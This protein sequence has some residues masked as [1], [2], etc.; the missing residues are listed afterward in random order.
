MYS[1]P[2]QVSGSPTTTTSAPAA[3]PTP[4]PTPQPQALPFNAKLTSDNIPKPGGGVRSGACS[5]SLVAPQWVV[6]AGHCFHDVKDRPVSGKPLYTMKVV[7]GKLK[8]SDAGGYTGEVID[9]R[10]SQVNDLAVVKLSAPV[11]DI[12]PLKLAEAKPKSGQKLRFAGWGSLSPTVIKP[13]DH[14]KRGE[15]TVAKVSAATMEVQSVTQKTVENSPC[16]QDSGGPFFTSDDDRTGVLVA[17]VN[18]GPTC[19]QP[20]R[21]T[22]ARID[23]VADWITRQTGA[24]T[25]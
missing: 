15:F 16:K 18:D 9:V 11:P 19:P 5:G 1:S 21:E 13:S 25:S 2:D 24:S 7:I 12:T 6:T 20:G 4:A 8:D 17:I 23:V 22:V 3:Q 14:L 10:Q